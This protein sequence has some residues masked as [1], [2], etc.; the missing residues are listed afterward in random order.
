MAGEVHH[1][2][3]GHGVQL[4]RCQHPVHAVEVRIAAR[5]SFLAVG[6]HVREGGMIGH[7]ECHPFVESCSHQC[8]GPALRTSLHSHVASV[9]FGQRREQVDGAYQSQINSL[10]VVVVAVVESVLKITVG[11]AH[12][13][14]D[15]GKLFGGHA[16]VESVYFHLH[17]DEPVLGIV[18]VAQRFLDGLDAGSRGTEHHRTASCLG[19]LGIEKIGIDGLSVLVHVEFHKK[20]IYLVGAVFGC[21][22]LFV[23][24]RHGGQL[25]HVLF[26]ERKE[27][28]RFL[29]PRLYF[30]CRESHLHVVAVGLGAHLGLQPQVAESRCLARSDVDIGPSVFQRHLSLVVAFHHVVG[31]L[32]FHL[33]VAGYAVLI[34][35]H[36][37]GCLLARIVEPVGMVGN[38]HPQIIRTV[39]IVLGT[40]GQ[41]T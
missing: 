8:Q 12:H 13:L 2:V 25:V 5:A 21:R 22:C 39:G 9:P 4:F 14:A 10:H 11:V 37:D 26:P 38:R 23:F 16:G 36:F 31:H 6:T 33:R 29:G 35:L 41:G 20:G 3:V 40:Q 17:A 32:V 1:V 27:V 28:G 24:Q 7:A 34:E 30:I 19:S 18:A 15:L